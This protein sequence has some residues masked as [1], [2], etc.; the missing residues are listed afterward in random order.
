M[1]ERL[2]FTQKDKDFFTEENFFLNH[3]RT[4]N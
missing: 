3:R 4:N 2:G 1:I